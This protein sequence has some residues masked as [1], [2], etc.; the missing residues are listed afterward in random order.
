VSR[1][2]SGEEQRFLPEKLYYEVTGEQREQRG[3]ISHLLPF[4]HPT[5]ALDSHKAATSTL[6]IS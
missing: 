2:T 4:K 1:G 6:P 3:A 5:A